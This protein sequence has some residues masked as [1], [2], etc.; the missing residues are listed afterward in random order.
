MAS[1]D[2]V[3]RATEEIGSERVWFDLIASLSIG[4]VACKEAEVEEAL[5]VGR[6]SKY[7]H[8]PVQTFSG[9]KV[10]T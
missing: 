9:L 2:V 10:Y 1:K 8:K 7:D 5:Q 3:N 4:V 6:E